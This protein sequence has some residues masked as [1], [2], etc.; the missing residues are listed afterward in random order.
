A[1]A[2]GL[3]LTA[4]AACSFAVTKGPPANHA[5]LT[6]IDCTDAYSAVIGDV[7]MGALTAPTLLPPVVFFASAFVGL[8]R[9]RACD[10]AKVA[11]AAA[12]DAYF[13]LPPGLRPDASIVSVRVLDVPDT[14]VVGAAAPA[15]AAAL[16]A[17]G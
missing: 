8:G 10:A 12:L 16:T 2:L 11:R 14:L 7:V 17:S 15:R 6:E 3:I 13:A 9:V 4:L 1:V 5:R